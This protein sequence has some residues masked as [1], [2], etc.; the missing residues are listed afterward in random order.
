M[1]VTERDGLI[2]GELARAAA[3]GITGRAADLFTIRNLSPGLIISAGQTAAE[4]ESDIAGLRSAKASLDGDAFLRSTLSAIL[5]D[6]ITFGLDVTSNAQGNAELLRRG[7]N[8]SDAVY[9]VMVRV[10]AAGF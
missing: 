5:A 8:V 9:R 7:R 4:L 10:L 3:L 2:L 1:I 6:I